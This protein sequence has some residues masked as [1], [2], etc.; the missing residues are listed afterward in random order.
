MQREASSQ[1]TDNLA[2]VAVNVPLPAIIILIKFQIEM[3][4]YIPFV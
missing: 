2:T 3:Q 4:F 1:A